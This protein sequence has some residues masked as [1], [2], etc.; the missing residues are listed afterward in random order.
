MILLAQLTAKELIVTPYL[1]ILNFVFSMAFLFAKKGGN[2][3][4]LMVDYH[5]KN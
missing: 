5:Y 4:Y 2:N 3:R 1:V